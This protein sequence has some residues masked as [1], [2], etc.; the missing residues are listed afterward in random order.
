[1]SSF[2]SLLH[3]SLISAGSI[4]CS[5]QVL[6]HTIRTYVIVRS[7]DLAFLTL[8]IW[9]FLLNLHVPPISCQENPS[10]PLLN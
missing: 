3:K 2:I 9:L 10:T 4:L 6:L 5:S 7:Q 8:R 1:M